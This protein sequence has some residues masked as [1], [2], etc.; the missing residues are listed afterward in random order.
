MCSKHIKR[1]STPVIIREIK[2]KPQCYLGVVAGACHPKPL[3]RITDFQTNLGKKFLRFPSQWKKD[4][5]GGA[6]LS[7]QLQQEA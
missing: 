6:Y 5:H 3:K 1:C 7:P 4:E 2:S